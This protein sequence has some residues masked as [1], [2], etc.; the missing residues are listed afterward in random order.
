MSKKVHAVVARSTFASEKAKNTSRSDQFSK[1]RCR[2]SARRC[3]VQRTFQSQNVQNTPCTDHF[4]TFRS[5]RVAGARDC[6]PCQK[7]AKRVGLVAFL[8]MMAGTFE[9][10]LQRCIF[11]GRRSARDMYIR[12]VRRWGRWFREKRCILEQQ[13]CSFAKMILRDRSTSYDLASI[14]S[15]RRNTLDRWGGKIA[16]GIGMRLSALHSTF[17]FWRKSHKLFHFWCCQLRK[18]RKSCRINV[19]C[20]IVITPPIFFGGGSTFL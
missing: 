16:K 11:R 13:I 3:G 9:E 5:F 7:W 15:G 17:H 8:K 4:W 19:G 6:A 14:F 12:D 20:L 1:L 2:K 10:D 18:F